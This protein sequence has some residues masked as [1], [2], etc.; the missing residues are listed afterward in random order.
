MSARLPAA[1]AAALLREIVAG[2][3]GLRLRDARRPWV[4][5]AVGECPV[6]AGDAQLVFFADSAAL[7][8]VVALSLPDGRGGAFADWLLNDGLNPLDLLDDAERVE[9]EHR[10]NEAC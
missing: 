5:I 8:H 6:L 3:R 7:D 4:R 9:L 1:E 10:L 2:Q